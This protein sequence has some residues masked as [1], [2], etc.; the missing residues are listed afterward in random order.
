PEITLKHRAKLKHC[1]I[2]IKAPQIVSQYN[3]HIG[4][5]DTLDMI[6]ALH[7]IPF[8]SRN[9]IQE[10]YG[11]YSVQS[12]NWLRKGKPVYSSRSESV[13]G[14]VGPAGIL[15]QTGKIPTKTW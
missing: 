10:S 1:R 6:V 9:G 2:D 14:P 3:T 7:L 8:R 5:V 13:T 12:W 11:E 4:G 15:T